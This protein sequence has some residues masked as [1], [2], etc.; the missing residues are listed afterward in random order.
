[1]FAKAGLQSPVVGSIIVGSV[2]VAGTLVAATLMDRAGRRQMILAS[3]CIMAACLAAL[4]ASTYLPGSAP[5]TLPSAAFLL[6]Q[7]RSGPVAERTGTRPVPWP[8]LGPPIKF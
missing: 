8:R 5:S 1:M 3:H 7:P 2:N 4:A 6:V